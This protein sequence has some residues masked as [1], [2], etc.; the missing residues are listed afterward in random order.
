MMR[1]GSVLRR[2]VWLGSAAGMLTAGAGCFRGP[3]PTTVD[4]VG[5]ACESFTMAPD[6]VEEP[7]EASRGV[8]LVVDTSSPMG[9]YLPTDVSF[10]SPYRSLLLLAPDAMARPYNLGPEETVTFATMGSDVQ[11]SNDGNPFW[12]RIARSLAPIAALWLALPFVLGSLRSTGAGARVALGL[13]LGIGFFLLQKMLESGV[14]V[15]GG[16]PLLMAWLP[17]ILMAL[18]AGWMLQRRRRF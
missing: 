15:F 16:S 1:V 17:T 18:A 9:G 13:G 4:A 12:S 14:S 5:G 8:A 2:A 6:E 10:G 3:P 7:T 11:E